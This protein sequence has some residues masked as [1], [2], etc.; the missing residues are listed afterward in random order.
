MS[1]KNVLEN[2]TYLNAFIC[3][4]TI[5]K[6]NTLFKYFITNLFVIQKQNHNNENLAYSKND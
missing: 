1:I 4:S 6:N 5:L 2:W 3:S